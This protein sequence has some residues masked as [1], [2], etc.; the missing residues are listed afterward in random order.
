[1]IRNYTSRMIRTKAAERLQIGIEELETSEMKEVLNK[2]IEEHL[3]SISNHI[4][5]SE[6]VRSGSEDEESEFD[7]DIVDELDEHEKPID[8][9]PVKRENKEKKAKAVK[10]KADRP[11]KRTKRALKAENTLDKLKSYV[12]KCGVRKMWKKELDGLDEPASISKVRSILQMLGMEGRPS[13][14]KCKKIKEQREFA[15]E[16][17]I[18]DK[19]RILQS[20]LRGQRSTVAEEETRPVEKKIVPRLDLSAFGDSESE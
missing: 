4:F 6:Q 2:I 7:S 15:E 13:L 14:E 10:V 17:K 3:E 20:R 9:I 8:F 1:M 18:I 16:M 12:F 5:V 11:A 19:S